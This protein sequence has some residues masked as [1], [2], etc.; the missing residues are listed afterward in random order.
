MFPMCP[1]LRDSPHST[2]GRG[3]EPDT[4]LFFF[5]LRIACQYAGSGAVR[6]AAFGLGVGP[7]YIQSVTCAG[8]EAALND[9]PSTSRTG[10]DHSNDAGVICKPGKTTQ[11]FN[12]VLPD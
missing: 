5:T 2:Y 4:G 12:P 7:I 3:G 11:S 6:G 9:C 8:T 1:L 10:C